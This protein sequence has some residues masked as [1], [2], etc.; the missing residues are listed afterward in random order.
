VIIIARG[1]ANRAVGIMLS[2]I[3][4][5]VKN[6]VIRMVNIAPNDMSSP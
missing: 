1:K 6:Q 2:L 3:P 4:I 5:S